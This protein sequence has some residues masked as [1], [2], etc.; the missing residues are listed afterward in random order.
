MKSAI[1]DSNEET[2]GSGTPSFPME[3]D[4]QPCVAF[5][6]IARSSGVTGCR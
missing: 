5:S 1:Y 3:S 4:G 2:T 6:A